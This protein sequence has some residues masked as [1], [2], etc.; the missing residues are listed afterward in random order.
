MNSS[1]LEM[2]VPRA[3]AK[4][5]YCKNTDVE[6]KLGMQKILNRNKFNFKVFIIHITSAAHVASL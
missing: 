3:F 1:N 4:D 5:Y 6:R 2:Q